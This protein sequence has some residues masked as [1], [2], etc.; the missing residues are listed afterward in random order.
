M[1]EVYL[2]KKFEQIELP[3]NTGFPFC[4]KMLHFLYLNYPSR[5]H[6]D[7]IFGLRKFDRIGKLDRFSPGFLSTLQQPKNAEFDISCKECSK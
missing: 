7:S 6:G 1:E 3:V 2:H 5:V 4:S